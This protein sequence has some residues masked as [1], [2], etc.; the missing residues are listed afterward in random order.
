M[1]AGAGIDLR[2]VRGVGRL[3]DFERAV[4]LLGAVAN[5]DGED[6]VDAG[7]MGAGEDAR[8]LAGGVHVEMGVRVGQHRMFKVQGTRFE[9]PGE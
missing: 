2:E 9:V 1:D 7:R 4:H 6:G 8:K 5:A 3:R